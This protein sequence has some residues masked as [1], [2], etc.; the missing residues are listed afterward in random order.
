MSTVVIVGA[1]WGDE[2][3][4]KIIDY[5]A[6]EADVVVRAQGG[7]N[8]GH[9]VVVGDK[10]YA[11]HLIPSGILNPKTVNIIGNGV[12][13]D[14]EGFLKEVEKIEAQGVC[15]ENIKISDRAHVIFP[16]HKVIDAL[17][18]DSRGEEMIGTTKKGIGPCYMDKVER[19]GIRICDLMNREVFID[20]VSKQI[21]KKNEIIEKIYG[22]EKLNK[23]E[24]IDQYLGY[25]EQIRKYVEDTTVVVYE[26]VKADKKVLFEGA[27]G[28]L[29]D[30][31]LGTYPYV[32]SSHPIS[33]GFT[34]GSGIGPNM[35]QEVV[36]VI[37]AYTTR[38]GKGPFVTEQDNEIG[39]RI[40]IA[41]NEFGTT[42]GRPR[43]CGWFDAVMVRYAARIN[44]LTALSMMLLDVLTGFEQISICTGYKLG[45]KVIEHFPA[46]LETLA[47]CEPIY[48]T[49]AGWSEDITQCTTYEDLPE[50]ARKYIKRI[51]ELIDV[52]VK[53][54]SVGPG[55]NQTIIREK[56]Y[57]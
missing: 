1:Q 18:E 49:M 54:I 19:S 11:L 55:R 32:T 40:R 20:K 27:Q 17:A 15:T 3:K 39:N 16:Y 46:C 34:V 35:I 53:I 6:G 52:P 12:V 24:I 21:D 2:G 26:A 14:P 25:A 7:N 37:K 47:E 10:K 13:F 48:E 4:G 31:D 44:G 50:N 51:E 45:D 5:L 43:R 33:G 9:T 36:G 42:T 8:A 22:G 23:Q 28:T 57:R 29:L 56:I 30:V 41:G 38:V